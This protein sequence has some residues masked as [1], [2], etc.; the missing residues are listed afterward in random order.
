[1]WQKNSP[2]NLNSWQKYVFN[3][4]AKLLEQ[5]QSTARKEN[6]Q[7]HCTSYVGATIAS[8]AE[9]LQTFL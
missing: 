1:M 8:D 3:L 6:T 7:R 2:N 5:A 4:F 9:T